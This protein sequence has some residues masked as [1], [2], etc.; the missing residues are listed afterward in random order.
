MKADF[1]TG[2]FDDQGQTPLVTACV[3][4]ATLNVVKL[5]VENG[6]RVDARSNNDVHL[7]HLLINL[8]RSKMSHKTKEADLIAILSKINGK[9]C[10][11][12]NARQVIAYLLSCG[13]DAEEMNEQEET[14]LM[15][16]AKKGLLKITA[17]LERH[18]L[19][20]L[21]QERQWRRD[22]VEGRI[23]IGTYCY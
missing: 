13:A 20:I 21:H 8:T 11:E 23:V 16:A 7:V 17:V 3:Y 10:D 22:V 14:P 15:A 2:C 18:M 5:L 19:N 4:N 6:A 9:G 1:T 12:E